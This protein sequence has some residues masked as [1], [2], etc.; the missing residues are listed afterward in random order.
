MTLRPTL[1]LALLVFLALLGCGEKGAV[2]VSDRELYG[3]YAGNFEA[4][5]EQLILRSDKTYTQIFESPKKQFT[6][7]GKWRSS[8]A[9]LGGTEVELIGANRT[10]DDTPGSRVPECDRNLQAHRE[11]GKLKLA[12]NETADW[13]YDRVD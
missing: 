9:F 12:L 13:Y 1:G 7:Q 2:R 6:H 3:T 8:N 5:K 10:E 4:G 11:K